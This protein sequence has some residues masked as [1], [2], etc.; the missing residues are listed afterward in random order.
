MTLNELRAKWGV[1]AEEFEQLGAMVPAST[2]CPYLLQDL[3]ILAVDRVEEV[4]SMS[5]ASEYSGYSQAHL[6]RMARQ[7]KV[8]TLRPP[9]ARGYIFRSGDLPQ[10]PSRTHAIDA[11][12][13]ELA[14]RLSKARGKEAK[15]GR[16]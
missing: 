14:S 5:Q 2:L 10:K 4:L 9:G 12:V 7:G 11:G 3:E 1:R 6:A 8:R 13:H 15:H 16:L